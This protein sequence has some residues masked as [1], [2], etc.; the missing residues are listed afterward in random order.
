MFLFCLLQQR[1]EAAA[2]EQLLQLQAGS[3]GDALEP[4][5]LMTSGPV[6]SPP[7]VADGKQRNLMGYET[8]SGDMSPEKVANGA[9]FCKRL[10]EPCSRPSSLCS[11]S[12]TGEAGESGDPGE[13]VR[14]GMKNAELAEKKWREYL[15][16][17]ESPMADFF[18]GQARTCVSKA[19]G[20]FV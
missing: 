14:D 1:E 10:Q 18:A 19:H 8:K 20:S 3:H 7:T 12:F 5:V 11:P 9:S 15:K 17:Q 16:E 4:S 2:A 6:R 13:A